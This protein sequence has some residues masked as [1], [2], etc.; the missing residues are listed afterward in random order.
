MLH[1][2]W[3]TIGCV[4][5]FTNIPADSDYPPR[6]VQTLSS[7][8]AAFKALQ[9]ELTRPSSD[10]CIHAPHQH[11]QIG[12]DCGPDIGAPK[13]DPTSD[14]TLESPLVETSLHPLVATPVPGKPYPGGADV[15]LNLV[16]RFT[17]PLF[18]LGGAVRQLK[19][20]T[21][22]TDQP[23]LVFC[24]SYCTCSPANS[25]WSAICTGSSS[26]WQCLHPSAKQSRG[27][28][29]SRMFFSLST[30]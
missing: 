25:Q 15:V 22:P 9:M 23:S 19:V 16:I 24:S 30:A 28:L 1:G 12:T 27:N 5:S 18:T 6:Y 17:N 26:S 29:D 20:L 8:S 14:S 10:V 3:T 11:M 13:S 21:S 2:L 4:S 7:L